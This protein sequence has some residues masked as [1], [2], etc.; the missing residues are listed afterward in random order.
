MKREIYTN[1][2]KAD[3]CKITCFTSCKKKLKDMEVQAALVGKRK[4][5]RGSGRETGG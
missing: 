2:G 5:I 1:F 4:G 3:A